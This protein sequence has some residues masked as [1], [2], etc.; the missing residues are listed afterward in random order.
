MFLDSLANDG[1]WL[2]RFA[3]NRAGEVVPWEVLSQHYAA[4]H[5][6]AVFAVRAMLAVPYLEKAL[7][8]MEESELSVEA[9]L[10]LADKVEQDVQVR[11]QLNLS[12][13]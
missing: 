4:S 7:Y 1:A 8:E 13:F 6:Y 3:R 10:K 12:S 11:S 5:P 9:L 2:G